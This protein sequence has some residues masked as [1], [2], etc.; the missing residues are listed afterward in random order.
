V[1]R[2]TLGP[3]RPL[4][5]L[6]PPGAH[7]G[8]FSL[9]K[10]TLTGRPGV[11]EGILAPQKSSLIGRSRGPRRKLHHCKF[12]SFVPTCGIHTHIVLERKS[13]VAT[14]SV[15]AYA[16]TAHQST[17]AL[18]STFTRTPSRPIYQCW[19]NEICSCELDGQSQ[20]DV[21]NQS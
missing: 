19:K 7:E 14:C 13:L 15:A 16:S 20:S 6:Q 2:K 10:S 9:P 1:S 17:S 4:T 3:P 8:K 18:I 21:P 12:P 11:Y 5:C